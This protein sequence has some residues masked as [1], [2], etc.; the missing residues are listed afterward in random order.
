M[1]IFGTP[2]SDTFSF[3]LSCLLCNH[4]IILSQQILIQE[5]K[6]DSVYEYIVNVDKLFVQVFSCY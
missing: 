4:E 2:C 1:Y 5:T 6:I 3:P